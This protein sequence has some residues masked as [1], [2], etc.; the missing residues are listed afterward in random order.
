[1]YRC[2]FQHSAIQEISKMKYKKRYTVKQWKKF[3]KIIVKE[4]NGVKNYFNMQE[5][6]CK[7]YDIILTDYKTKREQIISILKKINIKN[8]NSAIVAFSKGINTFNLAI[9]DFGDSMDTINKEFSSDI[10]KSNRA[11]KIRKKKNKKNLKRIWG[12]KRSNQKSKKND[13][14]FNMEDVF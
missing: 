9:Q 14:G 10:K 8:I 13:Y 1:M 6:L 12:K 5:L 2:N 11:A 4:N 7:K 3:N